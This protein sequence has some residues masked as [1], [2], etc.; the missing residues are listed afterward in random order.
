[1]KIGIN[2]QNKKI[3]DVTNVKS[4][5]KQPISGWSNPI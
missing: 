3:L 4:T 1:M 5:I 2:F